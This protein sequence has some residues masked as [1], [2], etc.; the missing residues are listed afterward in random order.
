MH[1]CIER[2]GAQLKA[3]SVSKVSHLKLKST[4]SPAVTEFWEGLN[5]SPSRFPPQKYNAP[6]GYDLEVYF[7][8]LG[9]LL[10]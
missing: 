5:Q 9:T 7:W 1:K 2:V 6:I 4:G 10:L 8:G 3:K